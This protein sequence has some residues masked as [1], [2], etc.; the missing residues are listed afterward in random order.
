VA[1]CCVRFP[2]RIGRVLSFSQVVRIGTP[3]PLTRRRVCPRLF[4]G[5]GHT[6][7]RER[8][9]KSP[10]SD[11]GTYTVV[12]FI[13]VYT[14]FLSSPI[15]IYFVCYD[16]KG[17]IKNSQNNRKDGTPESQNDQNSGMT[18]IQN[19]RNDILRNRCPLCK[20]EVD[21]ICCAFN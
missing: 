10:N 5:E 14:Y 18:E 3:P 4:W 1:N 9:W 20:G 12:L 7:R 6:R 21:R 17:Q 11:E 19:D 8:G 2:H 13:H 16:P 15:L